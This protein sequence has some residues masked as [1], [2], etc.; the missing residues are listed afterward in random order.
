MTYLKF[1]MAFHAL[2]ADQP[3]GV[4]QAGANIVRLQI[5]EGWIGDMGWEINPRET[6][7]ERAIS[8]FFPIYIDKKIQFHGSNS[9]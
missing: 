1:A 8:C 7:A 2:M 9:F 3:V 6:L 4:N 5:D